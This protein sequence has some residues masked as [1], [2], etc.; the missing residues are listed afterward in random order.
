MVQNIPFWTITSP[1]KT[2]DVFS[3]YTMYSSMKIGSQTVPC[4]NT[5]LW[6]HR[7][8]GFD[9]IYVKDLIIFMCQ[10]TRTKKTPNYRFIRRYHY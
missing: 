2:E 10:S 6:V 9:R 7:D 1:N 8:K 3:R 5:G 4:H